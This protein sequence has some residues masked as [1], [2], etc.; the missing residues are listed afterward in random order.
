[1]IQRAVE[2]SRT[3]VAAVA[4][5]ATAEVAGDDDREDMLERE[6]AEV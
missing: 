6:A 4:A 2:R 3:D 1:V 5:T